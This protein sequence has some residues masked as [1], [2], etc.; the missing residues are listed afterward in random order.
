MNVYMV[1]K[2]SF[3]VLGLLLVLVAGV[4]ID[5]TKNKEV[6]AAAPHSMGGYAWSA[7]VGWVSM[8]CENESTCGAVDYGVDL[9]SNGTLSGYAWNNN[10]GWISFNESELAGCPSGTCK[11]WVD[12][13]VGTMYGWARVCAGSANGNCTAGDRTDGWD[14]WISLNGPTYGIEIVLNQ[15]DPQ[16][17]I[18]EGYA[19]GDAVVGWLKFNGYAGSEV[20]INQPVCSANALCEPGIGEDSLSCPSDCVSTS[21]SLARSNNLNITFVADKPEV[22]SKTTIS[23]TP[24]GAFTDTITLSIDSVKDPNNQLVDPATLG[25]TFTFSDSTLEYL[26]GGNYATSTLYV[27]ITR[28]LTEGNYTVAVKGSG[29]TPTLNRLLDV[30]LGAK[31]LET[32]FEEF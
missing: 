11:A 1:K 24:I 27:D 16:N 31:V 28:V 14:G 32:K 22:S 7:N 10:I 2:A 3:F 19:W 13:V 21:F 5:G 20:N 25:M 6:R 18:F 23:A 8:S 26:G 9:A 4:F 29:G 30:I 12:P 17:K 15:N